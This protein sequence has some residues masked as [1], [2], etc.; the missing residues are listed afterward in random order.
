MDIYDINERF[1][2]DLPT[3]DFQTIGGYAFGLIGREPEIGDE[4]EAGEIKIKVEEMDAH[5]IQKLI[6]FK[7]DGF[8]DKQEAEEEIL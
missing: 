7:E 3:E 4:V 8:M 1:N 6:L 5:K 2:L